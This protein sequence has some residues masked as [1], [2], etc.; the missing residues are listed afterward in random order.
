[1]SEWPTY[2]RA[3]ES[4]PVDRIRSVRSRVSSPARV[5]YLGT[6]AQTKMKAFISSTFAD[7]SRHRAAVADAIERLGVELSRMETFGARPDE[8]F[9]ACLDEIDIADLFVGIYAHRYGFV[10]ARASI[11]ITEAEFYHATK[12]HR[13]TFCFVVDE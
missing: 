4:L 9:E 13:P 2:G 10:P 8:P 7:L 5:E 6:S 11:S 12:L 3:T 1:M